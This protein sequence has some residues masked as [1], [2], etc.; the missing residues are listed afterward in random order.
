[1]KLS[2]QKVLSFVLVLVMVLGIVPFAAFADEVQQASASVTSMEGLSIS[3]P[4]NTETVKQTGSVP[5]RFQAL[6]AV[7][8]LFRRIQ[9]ADQAFTAVGA[10]AV[11]QQTLFHFYH[12]SCK[13]VFQFAYSYVIILSNN[14]LF[15]KFNI[16]FISN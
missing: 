4:Y 11:I 5:S 3:Y 15:D 10:L 12:P 6:T 2:L 16:S 7:I 9:I 1:M 8:A 13:Q 14:N